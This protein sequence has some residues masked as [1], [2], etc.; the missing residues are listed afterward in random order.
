MKIAPQAW[1]F[2]MVGAVVGAAAIVVA[3]VGVVSGRLAMLA[4]GAWLSFLASLFIAFC[5]YF[6]RD[7]ERPLPQ[8]A[9]KL[10]SPGDGRVLSV[11]RE[12]PGSAVTLR[13]FLSVFDVHIQRAPCSG[14]VVSVLHQPGSFRAA[15][16]GEAKH[17]ERSVM[18]IDPEGRREPIIV[19][20][21]AGYVARRIETWPREGQSVKAGERYGIIYFGSQAAVH[22]PVSARCT[23]KP[24]DRVEAGLTP[25]G[26][27]L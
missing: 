16:V 2:V 6:F 1:R 19:E 8:D 7:P 9:R 21:I 25:V 20:Q 13:I 4:A 12:G 18:T 22:F 24:G 5:L 11:A 23:V 26:E 10:Y 15:M 3:V 14:R 27:W 17:N